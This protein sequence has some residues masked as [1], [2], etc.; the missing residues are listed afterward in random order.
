MFENFLNTALAKNTYTESISDNKYRIDYVYT[1]SPILTS[2]ERPLLNSSNVGEVISKRGL[3]T[4]MK[5]YLRHD[6]THP[7]EF[8]MGVAKYPK[9][10]FHKFEKS[11][12]G[13]FMLEFLGD[14]IIPAFLALPA[15]FII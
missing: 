11:P 14:H 13:L 2:E 7:L 8:M 1:G 5:Q 6:I 3:V 4:N 15:L 12:T 10:I 9:K